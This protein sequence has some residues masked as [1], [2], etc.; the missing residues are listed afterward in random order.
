VVD[1][2]VVQHGLG[3][4]T[5]HV[6]AGTPEGSSLFDADGLV[7]ELSGLDGGDVSSGSCDYDYGCDSDS[8]ADEKVKVKASER[9]DGWG[10]DRG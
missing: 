10:E 9:M 6:Q 4:D 1:V 7:T 3:R 5:S 8:D 2:R